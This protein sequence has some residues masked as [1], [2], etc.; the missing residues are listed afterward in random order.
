MPTRYHAL[1]RRA[2]AEVL[3]SA[4]LILKSLTCAKVAAMK[5]TALKRDLECM[6][7]RLLGD[8][9]EAQKRRVAADVFSANN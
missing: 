4:S 5:R 3:T 1:F 8:G 7:M 9:T 2:C 6:I